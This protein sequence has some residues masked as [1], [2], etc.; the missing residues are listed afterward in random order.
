[1][2]HLAQAVEFTKDEVKKIEKV[3]F[4]TLAGCLHYM[5]NAEMSIFDIDL[6]NETIEYLSHVNKVR[7]KSA[8][9]KYPEWPVPMRS[10]TGNT[11]D[12]I[13]K[14]FQNR[15]NHGEPEAGFGRSQT[16]WYERVPPTAKW[17]YGYLYHICYFDNKFDSRLTAEDLPD[18]KELLQ[19]WKIDNPVPLFKLIEKS[20]HDRYF[21][22]ATEKVM[23]TPEFESNGDFGKYYVVLLYMMCS[24]KSVKEHIWRKLNYSEAAHRP[25]KEIIE[26]LAKLLDRVHGRDYD[27]EKMIISMIKNRKYYKFEPKEEEEVELVDV[28]DDEPAVRVPKRS[29]PGTSQNHVVIE[30]D[31]DEQKEDDETQAKVPP[32]IYDIDNQEVDDHQDHDIQPKRIKIEVDEAAIV[33]AGQVGNEVLQARDDE[34]DIVEAAEDADAWDSSRGFT[35]RL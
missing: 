25:V 17:S 33:E 19:P 35:S 28:A 14:Y 23:R 22:A 31:E 1:M 24:R 8:T 20:Y 10:R 18:V 5:A 12:H 30:I 29:L 16:I 11:D 21:A 7:L 27:L 4:P 3:E 15:E 26:W 32:V 34:V 13:P 9:S 6:F 2:T